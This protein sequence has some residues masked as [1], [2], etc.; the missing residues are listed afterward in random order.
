MFC[1]IQ[2][3]SDEAL[4]ILGKHEIDDQRKKTVMKKNTNFTVLLESITNNSKIY[5]GS[6]VL[7]NNRG[8]IW[9]ITAG[10]CVATLETGEVEKMRKIRV[11][12]PVLPN[13]NVDPIPHARDKKDDHRLKDYIVSQNAMFIYP[14]YIEDESCRG[15]TDMGMHLFENSIVFYQN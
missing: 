6:G 2:P 4:N 1:E 11:R 3:V 8:K 10:H 15:G 9:V 13:Y 12:C 5:M 7:V 14:H